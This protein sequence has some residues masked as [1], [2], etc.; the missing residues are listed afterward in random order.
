MKMPDRFL[1]GGSTRRNDLEEINETIKRRKMKT[2]Y[3]YI[4]FKQMT[5]TEWGCFNRRGG[6]LLLMVIYYPKWKR[7]VT[8]ETEYGAVFSGD[9]HLDIAHFLGQLNG[10][11]DAKE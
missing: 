4:E 6:G 9:C 8:G 2:E 1:G 11:N 3:K 5:D 10:G 7:W